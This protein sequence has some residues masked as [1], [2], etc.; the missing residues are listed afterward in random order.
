[1]VGLEPHRYFQVWVRFFHAVF[2][3]IKK[4]HLNFIHRS[5]KPGFSERSLSDFSGFSF[6]S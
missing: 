5:R 4:N 6:H 1:M 2:L 3:N